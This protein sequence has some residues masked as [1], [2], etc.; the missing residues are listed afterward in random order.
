[1][2]NNQTTSLLMLPV[3]N[4]RLALRQFCSL[5]LLTKTVEAVVKQADVLLIQDEEMMRNKG[6]FGS[7]TALHLQRTV[8]YYIGKNF[9][10]RRAE[11][12]NIRF[13]QVTHGVNSQGRFVRFKGTTSKATHGGVKQ[14]ADQSPTE[15]LKHYVPDHDHSKRLNFAGLISTYRFAFNS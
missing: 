12:T 10:L 5:L 6:V 3:H 1:M 13:G 2:L 9:G 15:A 7:S 4:S 8:Y 11:Q 14:R